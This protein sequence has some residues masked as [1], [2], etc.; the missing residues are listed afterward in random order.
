MADTWPAKYSAPPPGVLPVE[1]LPE[2]S[3]VGIAS[4]PHSNVFLQTQILHLVFYSKGREKM[5]T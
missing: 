2:D 5:Y 3:A 1:E 4:T